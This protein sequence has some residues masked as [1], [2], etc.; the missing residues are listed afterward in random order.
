MKRALYFAVIYLASLLVGTLVFA[1]FFMLSCNL[2]MFVTGLSSSFFSIHFFTTGILLSIP[3]VC[4]ITQILLILYMIRHP[5]SQLISLIMYAIFG[6]FSWLVLIPTDLK[7][8]ARYESDNLSPRIEAT[9]PGIFRKESNGVFYFSRLNDDG[10]ADGIFL[11]TT[12]YLGQEGAVLPLFNFSV[13]TESAYPYSDILIKNSLQPSP[14]VIYPFAV[15]TSILTAAQYSSSLGFLSWLAFASLGL[16]LLAVY[17]I[18]FLSSWKLANVACVIT[19]AAAVAMINYFYYMNY[20]PEVLKEVAQKLSEFTGAKDPLIILI[21]FIISV[22]F[23]GFGIF[24]GIYRL[25][26]SWESEE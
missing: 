5:K 3:L 16:A 21:N 15:Y 9:S 19:A 4:V 25:N 24:M 20:L 2:T 6:V 26:G 17:G 23:I 14:L 22:L 18:Q 12:G 1:T 10:T 13:K 7:L 8:I 11:D